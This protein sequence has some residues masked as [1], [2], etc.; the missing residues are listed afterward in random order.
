MDIFNLPLSEASLDMEFEFI[1][2]ISAGKGPSLKT[3]AAVS[4]DPI[5]K[6]CVPAGMASLPSTP[7]LSNSRLTSSWITRTLP[8]ISLCCLMKVAASL[9]ICLS[10]L[11]MSA[12]LEL[13]LRG[14]MDCSQTPTNAY[15]ELIP[16]QSSF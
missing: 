4:V 15:R 16:A 6:I 10:G 9:A 14:F 1:T 13:V 8:L 2:I 12:S 5:G 7:H 11:A 3:Y